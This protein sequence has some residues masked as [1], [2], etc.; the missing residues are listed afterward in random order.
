MLAPWS[1]Y[2]PFLYNTLINA[3]YEWTW[4]TWVATKAIS[5]FGKPHQ[6]TCVNWDAR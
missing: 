2:G 6:C 3:S 1:E 4:A 5:S